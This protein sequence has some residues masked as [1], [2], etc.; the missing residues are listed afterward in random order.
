[1]SVNAAAVMIFLPLI[2]APVIYLF[3]RAVE[4]TRPEWVTTAVN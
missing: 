4:K 1:M 2:I 3:G